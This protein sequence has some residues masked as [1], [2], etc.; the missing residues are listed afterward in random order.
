[1][2]SVPGEGMIP[3]ERAGRF[4]EVLRR[5]EIEKVRAEWDSAY[6]PGGNLLRRPYVYA[7]GPDEIRITAPLLVTDG[8]P[9][10]PSQGGPRPLSDG[11][12]GEDLTKRADNV[13]RAL[14][15]VYDLIK[16]N[17]WQYFVTQTAD[18]ALIPRDDLSGI[19]ARM[20]RGVSDQNKRKHHQENRIRYLWVPELHSDGQSWHL[21]GVMAGL[22]PEDLRR[23]Q[24]GF[25][26]WSWSRDH[27]GFFSL[28]A[29]R[30]RDR[31]ASYIRK[32]VTKNIAAGGHRA[33]AHLYYC[34]RG[35]E[36]PV[37]MAL[38]DDLQNTDMMCWAKENATFCKPGEW[39]D[40]YTLQGSEAEAFRR[41]WG[42]F[43]EVSPA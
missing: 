31:T 32:Y 17:E 26:E 3:L 34:S 29:I 12:G 11:E 30:S 35:L 23:N 22:S 37:R 25:L 14:R 38:G 1:M 40:T 18:G 15:T 39:A 42:D 24:N 10:K 13:G 36:R 27:V 41:R 43:L 20:S 4:G 21:H 16:C 28:S 9:D 33:G 6:P 5:Q 8:R 7:V 2:K 19:V